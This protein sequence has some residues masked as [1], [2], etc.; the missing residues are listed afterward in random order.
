MTRTA[1]LLEN[2]SFIVQ[3]LPEIFILLVGY[4]LLAFLF[5]E[6]RIYFWKYYDAECGSDNCAGLIIPNCWSCLT[7]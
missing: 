2:E 7:I 3:Y 4:L 6:P 5:Y 1:M